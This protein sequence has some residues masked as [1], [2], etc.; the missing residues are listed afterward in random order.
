MGDAGADEAAL[1]PAQRHEVG[2]VQQ[3]GTLRPLRNRSH[4]LDKTIDHLFLAGLFERDGELVAVDLHDVAVAELLVEPRVVQPKLR[5]GAGGFGD[6]LAFDGHRTALVACEAAGI[7]ARAGEGRLAFIKA[8]AGLAALSIAASLATCAVGLRALPARRRIARAERFHVVEARR[9]VAAG[10]D[11]ARTALGFGD[12]DIVRRQFI[13]KARRDRG[14]P[15]AVN[16]PVGGKI[17]FGAGAGAGQADMGGGTRFL[18]NRPSPQPARNTL[19]NSSPLAECSVISDTAS[20]S[21]PPSRSIT[22]EMCSRKPCRFSNSSIERTSSL[23]F[24][25]RPAASAE[26]SFCHISV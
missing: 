25:S 26:R 12:L 18:G 16:P 3:I 5:W 15:G 22:S 7:A 2:E 17:E 21:A 8:A 1:Q 19:S 24:S 11:P 14:R 4:P 23:R 13:E 6:Q 20:S 10:A 9:A